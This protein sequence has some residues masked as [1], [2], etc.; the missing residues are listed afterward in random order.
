MF[1]P[2]E[3]HKI[4]SH[5]CIFCEVQVIRNDAVLHRAPT[6]PLQQ[7]L[8]MAF[9]LTTTCL[10]ITI[11]HSAQYDPSV[12]FLHYS[13]FKQLISQA[14]VTAARELHAELDSAEE[15]SLTI[16]LIHVVYHRIEKRVAN[17]CQLV[18]AQPDIVTRLLQV[19][20]PNESEL[21]RV[22]LFVQIMN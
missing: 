17:F 1:L 5:K 15:F 21:V 2:Q 18:R 8:K 14:I 19:I 9:H 20:P 16:S 22:L 10:T 11:L 13:F 6:R 12:L 3:E 7:F 4:F